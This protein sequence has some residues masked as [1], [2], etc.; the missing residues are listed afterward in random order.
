M[1]PLKNNCLQLLNEKISSYSQ[2][3]LAKAA[4]PLQDVFKRLIQR[5]IDLLKENTSIYAKGGSNQMAQSTMND[6]TS[7][8]ENLMAVIQFSCCAK[9]L[10]RSMQADSLE[11][12][13]Q[14]QTIFASDSNRLSHLQ[15]QT[16]LTL[17]EFY[18]FEAY[19]LTILEHLPA[20]FDHVIQGFAKVRQ[21]QDLKENKDQFLFADT[22][23]SALLKASISIASIFF[24]F[25]NAKQLEA[26]IVSIFRTSAASS[27]FADESS[28]VSIVLDTISM[29]A[30]T[31]K[32]LTVHATFNAY[33][34]VV[35][36]SIDLPVFEARTS[37]YFSELLC[38]VL[39]NLPSKFVQEHSK[40]L[41]TFLKECFNLPS[42]VA[43][44]GKEVN[45]AIQASIVACFNSFVVKLSE[46]QLRPIIASVTKWA[47]KEKS[48]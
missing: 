9:T 34:E 7:L 19:A 4:K 29:E 23:Q 44:Q 48:E 33:H 35:T 10:S 13:Q 27:Q 2:G 17:T 36:Q 32:K 21:V 6:L 8:N 14:Y 38:P 40:K 15:L 1:I 31:H 5:G 43:K 25:L 16:Q 3:F 47:M 41:T 26:L 18:L 37:R 20:F 30:K 42:K 28:Q 22:F 12:V 24:K 39:K 46:E 11:I 45:E